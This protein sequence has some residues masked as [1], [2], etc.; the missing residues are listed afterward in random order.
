VVDDLSP[1]ADLDDDVL[2][3]EVEDTVV[4]APSTGAVV[5]LDAFRRKK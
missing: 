4:K 1:D 5:S 2:E 3:S